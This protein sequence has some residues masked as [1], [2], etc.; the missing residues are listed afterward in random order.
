VCDFLCFELLNNFRPTHRLA[1][2]ETLNLQLIMGCTQQTKKNQSSIV[3]SVHLFLNCS[4][5]LRSLAVVC[6]SKCISSLGV[7]H[8]KFDCLEYSGRAF[9]FSN[10]NQN[11]LKTPA[12]ISHATP[13]GWPI[14][15]LESMD[16]LTPAPSTHRKGSDNFISRNNYPPNFDTTSADPNALMDQLAQLRNDLQRRFVNVTPPMQSSPSSSHKSG[17]K[18]QAGGRDKENKNPNRGGSVTATADDL[19]D[20]IV[21]V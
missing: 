10:N 18:G 7:L 15:S 11:T 1:I 17:E 3:F 21:S 13:I 16:F 14:R 12:M 8:Q 19:F 4:C 5:F 6:C 20:M 2:A 9:N